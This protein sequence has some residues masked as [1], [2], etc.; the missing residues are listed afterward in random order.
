MFGILKDNFDFKDGFWHVSLMLEDDPE[1][2]AFL[3]AHGVGA[4]PTLNATGVSRSR[5]KALAYAFED[6]A[7]ALKAP[8]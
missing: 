8:K 7:A 3:Q 2:V 6:L 1:P 4:Y 5:D